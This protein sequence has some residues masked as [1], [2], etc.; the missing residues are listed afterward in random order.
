MELNAQIVEAVISAVMEKIIPELQGSIGELGRK[1]RT[2]VDFQ[3][4]G[5]DRKTGGTQTDK[6]TSKWPT[7]S[8]EADNLIRNTTDGPSEPNLSD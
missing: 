2:K 6:M 3:S 4:A 1:L 7:S 8:M 5:L